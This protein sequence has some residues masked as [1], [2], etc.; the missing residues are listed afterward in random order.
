MQ[1]GFESRQALT[2]ASSSATGL[3]G[4]NHRLVGLTS[5]GAGLDDVLDLL[6]HVVEA[7]DVVQ[8]LQG[9][10]DVV[11]APLKRLRLLIDWQNGP[12]QMR[13]TVLER[14]EDP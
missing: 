7:D 9:P 4:D 13:Q 8:G 6:G 14:T 10:V 3:V 2:A 11:L 5:G 12:L 1:E